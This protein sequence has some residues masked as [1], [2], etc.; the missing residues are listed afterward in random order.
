MRLSGSPSLPD[1]LYNNLKLDAILVNND[2]FGG[3]IPR[4]LGNSR[5]SVINLTNKRFGGTIPRIGL[6]S[7][8]KVLDASH[9]SLSGHLLNMLSCLS[10]KERS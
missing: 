10:R 2:G 4:S 1:G 6:F 5:A 9:N 8:L 3:K 7:Q